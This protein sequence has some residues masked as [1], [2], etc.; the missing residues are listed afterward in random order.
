MSLV[1]SKAE[2]CVSRVGTGSIFKAASCGEF[3]WGRQNSSFARI[4]AGGGWG[5]PRLTHAGAVDTR[6]LGSIV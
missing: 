6:H 1:R 5:H 3:L 2:G 4:T